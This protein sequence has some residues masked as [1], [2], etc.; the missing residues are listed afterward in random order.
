MICTRDFF[1]NSTLVL[2]IDLGSA[3]CWTEIFDTLL[4]SEAASTE[5]FVASITL[6]KLSMDV[7]TDFVYSDSS[8][9]GELSWRDTESY[10]DSRN[11]SYFLIF[12]RG[13]PLLFTFPL[14][15]ERYAGYC[16]T[17]FGYHFFPWSRKVSFRSRGIYGPPWRQ[18]WIWN[19]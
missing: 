6:D 11:F 2:S 10:E 9:D 16:W 5:L 17:W 4:F 14:S 7:A 3:I 15:P 19:I 1:L 12:P 13:T 8:T 18:L